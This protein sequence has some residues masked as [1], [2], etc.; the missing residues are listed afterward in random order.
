MARWVQNS[1]RVNARGH[2]LSRRADRERSR[3]DFQPR[4]SLE[5]LTDWLIDPLAGCANFW[6]PSYR[7]IVALAF[8]ADLWRWVVPKGVEIMQPKTSVHPLRRAA[9]CFRRSWPPILVLVVKDFLRWPPL[10]GQDYV[11]GA[12]FSRLPSAIAEQELNVIESIP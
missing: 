11:E 9:L 2:R 6:S 3:A 1:R 8:A 5:A 10:E 4:Q 7:Q 12:G